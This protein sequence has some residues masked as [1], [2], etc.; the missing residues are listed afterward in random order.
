MA[1]RRA[2]RVVPKGN[3][4]VEG[5]QIRMLG[6]GAALADPDRGHS[7]ILVTVDGEHFLLDIGHGATRQMVRCHV[8]P[9]EVSRV[10]ISHLHFD[11]MEDA[12]YF[13]IASWMANRSVKPEVFGP[14]GTV[15]FIDSLLE[16]GAFKLDIQARAQYP[17][18]ARTM[19]MIRPKVVEFGPGVIYDD[20]K[21][22]IEADYVD[23]IEPD[24]LHCF[25]FRLQAK[26]R[27]IA[28][29]GD[30]R[31]CD[32]MRRFAQGC[33]LLIHECTF[34]QEAL[35][36]RQRT[37]IGTSAHT[38]PLELG[39]LAAEAGVK[40][41]VATHFGHFDTTSPVLKSYL[42]HHMPIEMVGPS[43]MDS[44][45]RDIRRHYDGPLR[46]AHDGMRIDL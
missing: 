43:F 39:R 6:T 4:T 24:L 20:G 32:T 26:G 37:G 7:S 18:R 40:S 30:T 1:A 36:F 3:R 41:L 29:S 27:T 33:D 34:P 35:D 28:F 46:I 19:E 13:L 31:P 5:I 44:V 2:G 11:H 25:G 14:P 38:S 8:N 15:H 22:R 21:V 12:A 9:A 17:Q 45:V 42:Q 23:H 10:F 16:N